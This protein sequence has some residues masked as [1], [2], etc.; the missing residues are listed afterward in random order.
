[1]LASFSRNV[2]AC[3]L[4]LCCV[5]PVTTL[6]ARQKSTSAKTLDM[7]SVNG[8][9]WQEKASPAAPLLLKLQILLDRAH[10]N[11]REFR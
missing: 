1:M 9:E 7:V 5:L 8:A 2:L 3:A 6:A 10:G 11:R 4:V